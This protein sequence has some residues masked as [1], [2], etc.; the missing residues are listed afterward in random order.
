MAKKR[1]IT[2]DIKGV[3]YEFILQSPQTYRRNHGSDSDAITYTKEKKVY[4]RRDEFTFRV[5]LH[6]TCHAYYAESHTASSDL[7]PDQVEE[8]FCELLSEMYFQIGEVC[9]KIITALN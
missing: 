7:T 9:A 8:V 5:V 2:I 4:F 1:S 3:P 6:E